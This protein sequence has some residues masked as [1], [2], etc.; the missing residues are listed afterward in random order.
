[1]QSHPL[2]RP[3]PG[4]ISGAGVTGRWGLLS[5][6][7]NAVRGLALFERLV[8]T[9]Q[10]HHVFVQLFFVQLSYVAIVIVNHHALS[11][12]KPVHAYTDQLE[13]PEVLMDKACVS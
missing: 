13:V 3:L 1:M 6:A 5:H 12:G 7:Q 4:L 10:K 9:P 8:E 2:F 11:V